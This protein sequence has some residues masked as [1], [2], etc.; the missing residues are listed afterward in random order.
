MRKPR[1]AALVAVAAL[2]ATL[3]LGACSQGDAQPEGE[4]SAQIQQSGDAAGPTVD[5]DPTGEL[6]EIK[7]DFG[8]IPEIIPVDAAP[9]TVITEKTLEAGDG[10][11]VG[12]DDIVTV[13]YAGFLWDGTPFDSSF[14]RGAPATFSLNAVIQ[15]WK[16]GLAGTNVGDRVLLIVPPE[17]GYGDVQ[18]GEI[19][20]D[21]TLVFVV[22]LIDA[23]GSDTTALEE[24]EITEAE[25]PE[26]LIVEGELGEKPTTSFEG[27]AK[28]PEE[29]ETVVIA[30][31]KGSLITAGDTVVYHYVGTYW[32]VDDEAVSTWESGAQVIEAN[33]SP[34]LG[35][36]VGSRVALVFPGDGAETPAMVMVV[37]IL[38][39][40]TPK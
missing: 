37:D 23:F 40:Y 32:G 24:A 1:F 6:P 14:G 11:E 31:G 35:E 29:E 20:A 3:G 27:D 25:L 12:L 13:N 4:Q 33:A 2:A 15:G 17:F 19:P 16:Y 39:A 18:Q 22:D 30:E 8:Q 9:P 5:R 10:P 7:G 38:A 26:G 36:R 28:A 21:S 34:F